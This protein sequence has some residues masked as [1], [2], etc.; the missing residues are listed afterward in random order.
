[1][2]RLNPSPFAAAF[3]ISFLTASM[4][5]A[6]DCEHPLTR[7]KQIRLQPKSKGVV[8]V[9][10]GYSSGRDLAPAL[11]AKGYDVIHVKSRPKLPSLYESAYN[12]DHYS[13]ELVHNG[14]NLEEIALILKAYSPLAV[15]TGAESG[16]IFAA[17]LTRRLGLHNGNDLQFAETFRD[18]YVM[19][20]V[21][22]SKGIRSVKQALAATAEQALA[23]ARTQ[24]GKPVVLKPK[25]SSGTNQVFVCK[26]EAEIKRAFHQIHGKVNFELELN[27]SVLV[28]EFLEGDEY[29][30]NGVGLNGTHKFSDIWL[31]DRTLIEGAATVYNTD[32][33]LPF[34]GNPQSE[35]VRY[36]LAVLE[37]L[38]IRNGPTHMEIKMTPSGPV[39]VDLGVRMS[40]SKV[41][42]LT[43]AAL[44]EGQVELTL[45]SILSSHQFMLR[46]QGY[47]LRKHATFVEIKSEGG[48]ALMSTRYLTRL[49]RLPGVI[50]AAFD[51]PHGAPLQ[52]TVDADTTIGRAWVVHEDPSV[53][54]ATV[55][56]IQKWE[57]EGRFEQRPRR[58]GR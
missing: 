50:L 35:L 26:T 16:P 32:R 18:K 24:N 39:V 54:N 42:R 20:E 37:A 7:A 6:I 30:V 56:T 49:E 17:H 14:S 22:R 8:V 38:G 13:G 19:G 48:G 46:P 1:M 47:T 36:A 55:R 28:Q 10:D 41:P 2:K 21:L 51:L 58:S 45:E 12:P 25:N 23:F 9:V 15:L 43:Q 3:L 33:L 31:Y 53:L 44:G 11:Q 4:A 40:G 27:T 29:A 52:R 34:E 5:Q 57:R